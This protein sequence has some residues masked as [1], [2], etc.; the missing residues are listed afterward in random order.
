MPSSEER[1]ESA[2]KLMF[3]G[4]ITE[5]LLQGRSL[6]LNV[7]YPGSW[8]SETSHSEMTDN[9]FVYSISIEAIPKHL[10]QTQQSYKRQNTGF[11]TR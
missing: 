7:I 1:A 2:V 11:S 9:E 3:L 8:A 4:E 10:V 5:S 6:N